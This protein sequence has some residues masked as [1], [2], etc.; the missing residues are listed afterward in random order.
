M[1]FSGSEDGGERAMGRFS[2][3][4]SG[5]ESVVVVAVWEPPSVTAGLSDI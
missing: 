3:A 4:E 1:V 2:G 5:F